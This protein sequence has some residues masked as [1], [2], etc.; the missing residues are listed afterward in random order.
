MKLLLSDSRNPYE[1]LAI[2]QELLLSAGDAVLLW[3]NEPCVVIGRHQNPYCETDPAYLDE[4]GIL[5]ARRTTGGGA[6]YHDA[7][8]L[9]YSLVSD[10]PCTDRAVDLAIAA[11]RRLG[12]HASF[13]GRN[14]IIVESAGSG[15]KIGGVAACCDGRF[16]CHGTIMVDVDLDAMEHALRPSPLKLDAHGVQ[17]VKARVANLR[18]LY[19]EISIPQVIQAFE[20]EL[21][22]DAIL[23][24][25]NDQTLARA[26]ALAS[27][28]WA[29][30]HSPACQTTVELRLSDGLYRFEFNVHDGL[31]R[32]MVIYTDSCSPS[33]LAKAAQSL[34]GV[35]YRPEAFAIAAQAAL[36][37]NQ[38]G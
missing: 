5:L 32:S 19:P 10:A 16:L 7:G 2:E 33:D 9:N 37:S 6:V 38:Q 8:N 3:A 22:C 25:A 35:E 4:H 23:T 29:F 15:A 27:H 26:K 17:S 36:G 30:G 14:D 34:E 24:T 12:V 20:K 21:G 28:P 13:S 11:L 18:E 31:I 1:N